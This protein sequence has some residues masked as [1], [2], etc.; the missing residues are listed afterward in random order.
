MIYFE[1]MSMFK[2]TN[3]LAAA[4]VVGFTVTN[5]DMLL[6]LLLQI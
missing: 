4:T 1:A 2:Y 6:L 3:G 5:L